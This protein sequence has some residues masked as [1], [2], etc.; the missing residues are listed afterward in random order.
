MVVVCAG[1]ESWRWRQKAAPSW[2][3]ELAFI[4][5]DM[6]LMFDSIH[7]ITK[8]HCNKTL[9]REILFVAWEVKQK[10]TT[11]RERCTRVRPRHPVISSIINYLTFN[12]AVNAHCVRL[13]LCGAMKKK[14]S[15]LCWISLCLCRQKRKSFGICFI[16]PV[17]LW[18]EVLTLFWRILTFGLC[19]QAQ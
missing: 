14:V 8:G 1:L 15:V 13:S 16:A 6:E 12:V 4:A 18:L 2:S 5:R 10:T 7:I 9:K 3:W 19:A 17:I 11:T